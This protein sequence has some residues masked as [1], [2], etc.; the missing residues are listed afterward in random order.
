MITQYEIFRKDFCCSDVFAVFI[1]DGEGVFLKKFGKSAFSN[2]YSRSRPLIF[3][4]R[5]S[6]ECFFDERSRTSLVGVEGFD[7]FTGKPEGDCV[8][9]V[10][11]FSSFQDKITFGVSPQVMAEKKRGVDASA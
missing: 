5:N 2:G 7:L 3:L 11:L 10:G 1:K 6:Y 4:L 9:R 8:L